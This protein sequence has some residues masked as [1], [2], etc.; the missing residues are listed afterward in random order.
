[1][2]SRGDLVR[3]RIARG[4]SLVQTMATIN[5]QLRKADRLGNFALKNIRKQIGCLMFD[6]VCTGHVDE[7]D[8][9]N[10]RTGSVYRS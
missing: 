2:T 5:F 9:D 4:R 1:M 7:K 3:I 6:Y 10:T 8:M